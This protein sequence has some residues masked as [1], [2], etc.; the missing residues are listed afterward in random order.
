MVLSSSKVWLSILIPT[1][2]SCPKGLHGTLHHTGS[3]LKVHLNGL[4][5]SLMWYLEGSC[6]KCFIVPFIISS[7]RTSRTSPG[8][9][10]VKGQSHASQDWISFQ[11]S[12]LYYSSHL[13]KKAPQTQQSK[14][15][16]QSTSISHSTTVLD[17]CHNLFSFNLY[18]KKWSGVA[19]KLRKQKEKSKC[20]LRKQHKNW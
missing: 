12:N 10:S 2:G 14:K 15:I 5:C 16:P 17:F 7:D 8:K 11:L 13:N 6:L 20:R 18:R 3:I 1:A 19:A 4:W 9:T